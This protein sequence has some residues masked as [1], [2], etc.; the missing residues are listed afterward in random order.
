MTQPW[1]VVRP[2]ILAYHV[3]M[4]TQQEHSAHYHAVALF[5]GGLDSILA[6]KVMQEQGLRV[7][8]LHFTSP[9]FGKPDQVARWQELH[10]LDIVCVD[11][12]S[13]FCAM[14]AGG[15]AHGF[16]KW[17]NPCVD[18]KILMV[19]RAAE[20]MEQY[21][22]FCIV[23]GE[24]LGQRPMSQRRD[25][26]NVISR[27]ARARELLLRPLCA[28]RLEPTPMEE[29][30]LV[31][32]ER[33]C[34]IGGRGRKDQ[35]ELARHFS[36]KEIPT[37][38]GGCLLAE[39]ESARRY[40]PLL[41]LASSPAA[42]DFELANIGRQYWREA[43][44]MCIGRNMSDN[45]RLEAL[46][47]PGDMSF[48]T[49]GYPGPLGLAR[50]LHQKSWTPERVRQGAALLASFSPK[51]CKAQTQVQV[52]VQCNGEEQVVAVTPERDSGWAEPSWE[53]MKEALREERKAAG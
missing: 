11:L 22:A 40:W 47:R 50:P 33:L 19:R 21:G 7:K 43:C 4:T 15:P 36:L 6:V 29:Q 14:L 18:C 20:L 23:S 26:L 28:K 32:R 12:A 9:F 16:G 13:E 25:T 2:A 30:G 24:V 17:L 5:S 53:A 31:D 51:A 39:C 52:R 42:Q 27:D 46:L 41:R 44:W 34:G 49:L 35:L 38:A 10:D 8:C 1:V 37:P 45:Q 3:L 48:K